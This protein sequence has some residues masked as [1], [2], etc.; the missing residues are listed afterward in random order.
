MFSEKLKFWA[1]RR[2]HWW[3][4]YTERSAE[5]VR[6]LGYPRSRITVVNNSGDTKELVRARESYPQVDLEKLRTELDLEA[7]TACIMAGSLT[8]ERNIPFLLESAL[9]I[10]EAVPDFELLILGSGP[11]EQK[12]RN[13]VSTTPWVKLVGARFGSDMVPYFALCK[14]LLIPGLVGLH[15]LDSFAL[16]VPLVTLNLPK[17][18]PEIVYLEDGVNSRILSGSATPGDYA[19][20]VVRLLRDEEQL[21]VLREGCR[22]SAQAY[23]AEDMS[24]RFAEGI[25]RALAPS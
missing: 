14:L 16:Q 20:E 17:H 13:S 3:F 11:E 25:V 7:R 10:R 12:L 24:A 22:R 19:N 23:S 8:P 5:V 1:S 18:G 21:Q 4:A 9:K 2:V 15:A 6:S